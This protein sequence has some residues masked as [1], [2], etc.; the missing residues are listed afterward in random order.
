MMHLGTQISALADGQLDP[1]ATERALSHVA[2][3]GECA[4]D[5][6][7][8]RQARRALAAAKDVPVGPDLAARLLALGATAGPAWPG[9]EGPHPGRPLPGGLPGAGPYLPADCLRG[10][11]T[12]R[13]R[14]PARWLAVVAAGAGVAAV[15]L[16]ALGEDAPV[17]PERHPAQALTLLAAAHDWSDGLP[18]VDLTSPEA[19]EQVLAWMDERG[20][21]RP[22][23]L[24]EGYRIVGAHVDGRADVLELD[25]DGGRGSIVV[26][27]Q[28][29]RLH[30]D[31]AATAAA[32]QVGDRQVHVLSTIP[33]HAVWQSG[34]TVVG[35][36]AEGPSDVV[37]TLITA[38]PDAEY[39]DGVPAQI[40]RGWATLAGAWSP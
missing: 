18:E 8:V 35:V 10:E 39:D 14:G 2:G 38:Y 23:A 33:W 11:L 22:A 15:G 32:T 1:S 7:A 20:W 16:F 9:H 4:A 13:R 21:P 25:L 27:Q 40:S 24:P 28:R 12:R 26:T 6:A 5:L 3:C 30:P 29:G 34:D 31:V 37:G 19:H 17:V 36:V